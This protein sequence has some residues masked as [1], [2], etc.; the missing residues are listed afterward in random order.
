MPTRVNSLTTPFT[1]PTP[2]TP[3]AELEIEAPS[4]LPQ[5][6]IK[7]SVVGC[8]YQD[9]VVNASEIGDAAE[10]ARLLQTGAIGPVDRALQGAAPISAPRRAPHRR[11][12][13]DRQA[14]DRADRRRRGAA[15][16]KRK[17]QELMQTLRLTAV[18]MKGGPRPGAGVLL[19]DGSTFSASTACTSIP[20]RPACY[21]RTLVRLSMRRRPMQPASSTRAIGTQTMPLSAAQ[22]QN[23]IVL[24]VGDDAAGT[25][26]ANIGTLW[27]KNDDRTDDY[28]RY[29]YSKRDAIDVMLGRVRAQVDFK[30][31]DGASV[32]LTDLTANF[33]PCAPTCRRRLTSTARS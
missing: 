1:A 32:N 8:W 12:A 30:A 27:L 23:L 19:P 31:L 16:F 5:Y 18:Y 17:R 4:D 10:I 21:A 15:A 14:V 9:E 3:L 11:A 20:T 6:Q 22:Y 28:A 13:D 25:L 2:P 29:L 7:H 24:Q 33:R 26:A